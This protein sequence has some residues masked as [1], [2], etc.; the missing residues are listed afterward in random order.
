MAIR[1]RPDASSHDAERLTVT[2]VVACSSDT[3]AFALARE[4][5]LEQT[6]ELPEECISERIEQAVV[7]R[8]DGVSSIDHST[9]RATVS[10]PAPRRRTR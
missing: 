9:W 7:G 2:Y 3:E 8:I 4:I 6:V 10:Y 1:H 5:A